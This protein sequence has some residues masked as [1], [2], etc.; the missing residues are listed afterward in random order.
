LVILASSRLSSYPIAFSAPHPLI[1][2]RDVRRN[3]RLIF[4][5]VLADVFLV[6]DDADVADNVVSGVVALLTIRTAS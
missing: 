6:A 1:P 4:I 2:Q 5:L 3:L